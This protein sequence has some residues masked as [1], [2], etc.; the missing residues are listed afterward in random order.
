MSSVEYQERSIF[1]Q[2]GLRASYTPR[3]GDSPLP[4]VH[5]GDQ[6]KLAAQARLPQLFRDEGA[7]VDRKRRLPRRDLV[8]AQVDLFESAQLR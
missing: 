7:F 2:G 4:S 6:G 5:A 3:T 1:V 8:Y